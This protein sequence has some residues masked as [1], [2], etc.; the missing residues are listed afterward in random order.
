MSSHLILILAYIRCVEGPIMQPHAAGLVFRM[1]I[2]RVINN[3]NEISE[4]VEITYFF[5]H[6]P[7]SRWV[8]PYKTDH[9]R[10]YG[11]LR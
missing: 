8:G 7:R 1:Y 9:P 10:G 6:W 5:F 3:Y 11:S 4:N 2:R